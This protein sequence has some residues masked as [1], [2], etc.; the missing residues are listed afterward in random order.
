MSEHCIKAL[1][2]GKTCILGGRWR[3]IV[4]GALVDFLYAVL[5]SATLLFTCFDLLCA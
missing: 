5:S 3:I 2:V 1:R 4:D